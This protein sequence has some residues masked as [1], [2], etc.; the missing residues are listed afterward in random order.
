VPGTSIDNK[1]VHNSNSV[2]CFAVAVRTGDI[3]VVVA[4]A[5]R[6]F[7][8]ESPELSGTRETSNICFCVPASIFVTGFR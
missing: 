2:C 7:R 4:V 3:I 5:V 6:T 1:T 8:I